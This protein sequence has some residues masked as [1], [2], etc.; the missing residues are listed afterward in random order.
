LLSVS[1]GLYWLWLFM[2]MHNPAP[3]LTT[4]SALLMSYPVNFLVLIANSIMYLA[5]G[6]G[7]RRLI[8]VERSSLFP[9]LIV[10]SM[11]LGVLLHI[12]N[13]FIPAEQ[14]MFSVSIFA[15]ASLL[16]GLATACFC[17]EVGRVFGLLGPQQVLFHGCFALF[18]G[19]LGA[20]LITL[21]PYQLQISL[22]LIIPAFMV[23]CL[24]RTLRKD[25]ANKLYSQGLE[26]KARVP[27]KFLGISLF[28]GLGVGVMNVLIA[29]ET[30]IPLTSLAL[31]SF[32][33]ATVLLFITALTVKLNFDHLIFRVG[34]PLMALGFF[35]ISTF[36]NALL[37]GSVLLYT[38]YAYTYLINC[39]L[40]AYFA[41]G[42]GQSPLWIIGLAT[43]SLMTGQ[44]FG[45]ILGIALSPFGVQWYAGIT[46]FLLV[47]AALLMSAGN[48]LNRGWGT[49]VPGV[50]APQQPDIET[51]C[52]LV[53]SENDL[54]K[55]E[56][57]VLLLLIRGRSR[58]A[59]SESLN[60][61]E[62]TIKSHVANIY[63]KIGVHS[64]EELIALAERRARDTGN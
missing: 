51:A 25:S 12:M 27:W 54:S 45:S 41:K 59:L 23:F 63:A 37:G 22:L 33:L 39:C 47:L 31:G 16:T 21:L 48:R 5:I 30:A 60:V 52:R 7:Y 28:Q 8:G 36:G 3:L 49:I 55:R 24:Y 14:S 29:V 64:R 50:D 53:A 62:E 40:C 18:G 38:G 9:Y 4:T 56:S 19:T 20:F 26:C 58:R 46:A 2:L 17:V 15:L 1:F 32:I 34:F 6:I 57:E 44:I 42:M 43:G 61:S 35:I 11:S 10:G 13:N